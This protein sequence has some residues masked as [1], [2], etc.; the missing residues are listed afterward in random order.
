[1]MYLPA[2]NLVYVAVPKTGGISATTALL[3]YAEPSTAYDTNDVNAM[4]VS[5]AYAKRCYP[6]ADVVCVVREPIDWLFSKYKYASGPYFSWDS[7]Y[8]TR[9][10][11]FSRFVK[12]YLS[13]EKPWPEP[14]RMQIDYAKGAD[15]TFKYENISG[16]E[17][18]LSKRLGKTIRLQTLNVSPQRPFDLQEEQMQE[19]KAL[20]MDDYNLWNSALTE[21]DNP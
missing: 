11:T 10:Q 2:A 5:S 14:Y 12:R 16:F 8:T 3:P 4:H 7:V 6:S 1:M 21:G 15:F 9:H 13:G 18:F 17:S 19:I 20:L